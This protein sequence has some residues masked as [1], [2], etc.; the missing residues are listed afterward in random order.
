LD[1]TGI[2]I[3]AATPDSEHRWGISVKSRSRNPGTETTGVSIHKADLEKAERARQAFGCE[4]YLAIVVDGDNVVQTFILPKH[5][6]LQLYPG[7]AKTIS[8]QLTDR[9]TEQYRNDPLIEYFSLRID[10]GNWR[11]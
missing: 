1:H 2:D 10:P 6:L 11:Q 4:L 8:W 7:G 3:I 9:R 5:H